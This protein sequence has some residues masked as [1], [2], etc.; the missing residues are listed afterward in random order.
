MYNMYKS[1]EK[2]MNGFETSHE[3]QI[4]SN[5]PQQRTYFQ[6]NNSFH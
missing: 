1:V 6:Q 4:P 2:Q 5:E 3:M